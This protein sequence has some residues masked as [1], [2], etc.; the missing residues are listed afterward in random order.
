MP[1]RQTTPADPPAKL[2][3]LDDRIHDLLM[4]RAGLA[5]PSTPAQQAR[6][7]RRL[8]A[9]HEGKLPLAMLVRIWRELMAATAS[10]KRT[11]H[12]YASDRA[13]LFRD[14]ARDLFGSVV[15]MESHL[16]ASAIVHECANDASAFGVVP[17]PES[18]ENARAW[19]T[20]LTP[21]G[22]RGPRV[23]A[24]LPLVGEERAL[25]YVIGTLEPEP[26]GDDTSLILLEADEKLSLT[27][28]QSMLK[29]GGLDARLVAVSRDSDN[30]PS[31]HHLFELPGVLREGDPRFEALL[32]HSGDTI[33]RIASVGSYANPL[34]TRKEASR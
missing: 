19:W 33:L 4:Q 25:A 30:S 1:P 5:A 17:P 2:D 31:R 3:A 12:V 13:G 29:Q 7:L 32:E 8:A 34:L 26:S 28:L 10:G 6:T 27:K 11:V 23:V 22:L 16:S 18:D 21:S 14:L 15:A 24:A 20:Q 9:R